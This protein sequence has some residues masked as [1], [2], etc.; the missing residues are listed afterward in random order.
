MFIKNIQKEAAFFDLSHKMR[1]AFFMNIGT[2]LHFTEKAETTSLSTGTEILRCWTP[3]DRSWTVSGRPSLT[4]VISRRSDQPRRPG[5]AVEGG[6]AVGQQLGRR[7]HLGDPARV[8]NHHPGNAST[9]KSRRH[10][11]EPQAKR[12]RTDVSFLPQ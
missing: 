1:Y 11:T 9:S 4:R 8:Q 10:T 6:F 2:S 7:P 3:A 5:H 12:T